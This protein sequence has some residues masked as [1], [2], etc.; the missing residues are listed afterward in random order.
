[1]KIRCPHCSAMI[2]V[3]DG[4]L[5]THHV[6]DAGKTWCATTKNGPTTRMVD[7]RVVCQWSGAKVEF[8]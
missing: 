7:V 3:L 2:T 6:K 5:P 8:P 4:I 1:M